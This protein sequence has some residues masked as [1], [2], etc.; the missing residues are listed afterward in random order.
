[1]EDMELKPTP[2]R[3]W[4]ERPVFVTG[5]TGLLGTAVTSQL[6]GE[7]ALVVGLVRDWVPE[8]ELFQ[9]AIVDRIRIV[10]GDVRDQETIE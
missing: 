7:G 6:V 3:F 4:S 2:G 10:H 5:C 1:M 8:C 9:P